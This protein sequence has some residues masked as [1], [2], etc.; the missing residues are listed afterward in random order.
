MQVSAEV[1]LDDD[2]QKEVCEIL[3][4]KRPEL[5]ARLQ[6]CVQASLNE[7]LAMFRGQKVF[8][9]GSDMLEYRLLL[10]IENLFESSIPDEQKVSNL[11]QTTLNES[12]SLIRSVLS[13]YQY[14]L[15]SAIEKTLRATLAK[16]SRESEEEDYLV[17]INS[18]NIVNE[19]NRRLAE[20][21]GG[22]DQ[23][24]KKKGSVSTYEIRP[25]SYDR[26]N[27]CLNP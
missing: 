22:L 10:L 27:A 9:R 8:K 4:C 11:F 12:R 13:K 24:S 7:Y 14:Q 19:L 1:S 3:G 23:V 5:D 20:I 21:D 18:Y 26:L 15:Q 25:A 17:V 6:E 16:A 2:E